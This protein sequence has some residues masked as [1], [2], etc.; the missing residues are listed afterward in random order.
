MITS[1]KAANAVGGKTAR[2][3]DSCLQK[4][5]RWYCAADDAFLCQGCDSSVHS[6][7]QL[8]SRHERVRLEKGAPNK[9]AFGPP[10][11]KSSTPAWLQGFTR[12]ARTPRPTKPAKAL[13]GSTITN[14]HALVPEIGAEDGDNS[15]YEESEEQ[16]LYRVPVFDPFA[17]ELCD[18]SND[19]ADALAYERE[20]TASGGDF[21][22][23]MREKGV[24][25]RDEE[26]D[27]D[28]HNLNG[29]ILP[30]DM[31]L[32][33]FAADVESLLGTGLD[34]DCCGI[35]GLGLG[36]LER[37]KEEDDEMGSFFMESRKVKVEDD[38]DEVEEIVDCQMDI[39]MDLERETIDW[40][41]DYE[42]N[43]EEEKALVGV[44][45]ARSGLKEEEVKRK[46][47]LSLNYEGVISSWASQGCPWTNGIRPELTTDDGWPE[48]MVLLSP[49]KV[50]YLHMHIHYTHI[51]F[52]HVMYGQAHVH[53]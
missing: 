48:F 37:N 44:M 16:L 5:A 34:E 21:A 50:T 30:S 14:P 22:V 38:V 13:F 1:K 46:M 51:F 18:A 19:M 2:A 45:D 33:E 28:L 7:N 52:I 36:L 17:A 10:N 39:G 47:I 53:I 43:G 27:I 20:G 8:A 12:K 15:P 3:C 6:A 40:N 23:S 41:F 9:A 42:I 11:T 35:E 49:Y 25:L 31:E 26:C 4:R 32:A 24:V 29:L